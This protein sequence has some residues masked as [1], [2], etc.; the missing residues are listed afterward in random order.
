VFLGSFSDKSKETRQNA[1]LLM[2]GIDLDG[3]EFQ[4][5]KE[6]YQQVVKGSG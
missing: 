3:E 4:T 2:L 1:W 5:H 6:F